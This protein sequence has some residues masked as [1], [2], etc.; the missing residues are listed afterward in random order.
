MTDKT[1]ITVKYKE[2]V[3]VMAAKDIAK[4]PYS[5]M[6]A[7]VDRQEKHAV[8]ERGIGYDAGHIL[9]RIRQG[10]A[11]FGKSDKRGRSFFIG[12]ERLN[13][14]AVRQPER[15]GYI[16]VDVRHD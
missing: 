13:P 16:A 5:E 15:R 12:G 1:E 9:S 7:Q 11:V 6:L 3:R 2:P 14:A 10:E 8:K 4:M